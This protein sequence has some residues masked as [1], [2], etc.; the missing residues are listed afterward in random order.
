MEANTRCDNQ[1]DLR[2]WGRSRSFASLSTNT[3]GLLITPAAV[4]ADLSSGDETNCF[5][6]AMSSVSNS[7]TTSLGS[8]ADR[9]RR[10]LERPA[11]RRTDA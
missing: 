3:S 5:A 1:P 8:S 2:A 6:F 10:M 4:M 11:L 9:K 7:M